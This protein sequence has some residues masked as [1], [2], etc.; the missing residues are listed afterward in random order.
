MNHTYSGFRIGAEIAGSYAES[1]VIN[2]WKRN[3]GSR[4]KIN[5]FKIKQNGTDMEMIIVVA[6]HWSDLKNDCTE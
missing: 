2:S 5:D 6:L 4:L 1:E 3:E